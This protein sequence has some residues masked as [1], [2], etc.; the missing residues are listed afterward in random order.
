MAY[1]ILDLRKEFLRERSATDKEE[2]MQRQQELIEK[3]IKE[4]NLLMEKLESNESLLTHGSKNLL[5][6]N[7]NAE[8]LVCIEQINILKEHSRKR[9]LDINEV[10]KLDLLIKNLRLIRSQPTEADSASFR[11]VTEVDLVAIATGIS[12]KKDF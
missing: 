7:D 4:N 10:K 3:L 1:S 12:S 6:G 11:D 9:E 2:F 8:E 5:I